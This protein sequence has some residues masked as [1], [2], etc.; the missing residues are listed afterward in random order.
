MVP[1]IGT[2]AYGMFLAQCMRQSAYAVSGDCHSQLSLEYC[3]DS[4]RGTVRTYPRLLDHFRASQRFHR[5]IQY[6]KEEILSLYAVY[7]KPHEPIIV[8]LRISWAYR[9]GMGFEWYYPHS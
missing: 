9:P 2:G 6:I 8:S 4:S 5:T 7:G 3:Y 1:S